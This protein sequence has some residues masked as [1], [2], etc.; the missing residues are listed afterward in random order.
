MKTLLL[1]GQEILRLGYPQGKIIGVIIRIVSENYTVEQK[2]YV[3]NFL[4]GV[5]KHPEKFEDH[6]IF[7]EVTALLIGKDGIRKRG[8]R[9]SLEELYI[10]KPVVAIS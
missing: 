2:E 6:I 7:G 1:T 10:G 9:A 4:R 5:L 8:M 3:I